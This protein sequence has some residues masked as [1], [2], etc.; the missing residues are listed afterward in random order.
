M[1]F[2]DINCSPDKSRGFLGVFLGVQEYS[3]S[4]VQTIV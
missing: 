4:G 2:L 3:S 1:F